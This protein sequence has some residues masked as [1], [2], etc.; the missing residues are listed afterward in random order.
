MIRSEKNIASSCATANACRACTVQSAFNVRG[1]TAKV[2]NDYHIDRY[3]TLR[4][5]VATSQ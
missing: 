5:N 3:T 1:I 4:H 2:I